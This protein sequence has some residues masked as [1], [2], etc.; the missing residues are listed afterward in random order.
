MS[1]GCSRIMVFV[2][3]FST[4]IR[5]SGKFISLLLYGD[6]DGGSGGGGFS[7]ELFITLKQIYRRVDERCYRLRRRNK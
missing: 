2:Y 7:A 1:L 5:F 4:G 6:D 3:S